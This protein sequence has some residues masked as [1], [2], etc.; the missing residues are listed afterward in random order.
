[1][2]LQRDIGNNSTMVALGGAL[3]SFGSTLQQG[4]DAWANQD[5]SNTPPR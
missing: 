4:N 5:T 2:E 1:M 3:Q